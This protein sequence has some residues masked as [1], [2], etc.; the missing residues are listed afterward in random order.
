MLRTALFLFGY[1]TAVIVIA[2]WV[3]VVRERRTRWFLIHQAAVASIVTGW[4]VT[5][6]QPGSALINGTWFLVAAL[7]YAI[8]PARRFRT[9]A[10]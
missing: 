5:D 9:T 10:S 7:W 2:R 3:P 6:P 8:D 1:P 4:L